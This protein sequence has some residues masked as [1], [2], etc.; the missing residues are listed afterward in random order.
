V[1]QGVVDGSRIGVGGWSYGGI[2]TNYMIASEPRIKAAVAGAGMANF[3]GGY[4]ADQYARDYEI[5]LGKPW[6][7][8]DRWKRLSYPFYEVTRIAAPTLYLC[9]EKD[10]N[11]PCIGSE[12]M[13]QALKSRG[14]PTRLVIYPGENHGLTVPS[15]LVD[16]MQRQVD[17]YDRYV[18]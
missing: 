17:W 3:L 16:R 15:Y 11:V 13:Y 8:F 1:A 9:A 12:Q 4:G 5:E 2:L 7:A 6:E 10:T 18:K 14:L